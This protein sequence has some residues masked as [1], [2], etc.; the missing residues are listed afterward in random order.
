MNDF[1]LR[2]GLLTKA[3]RKSAPARGYIESDDSETHSES[4]EGIFYLFYCIKISFL[5]QEKKS[6]REDSA[7]PRFRK[8]AIKSTPGIHAQPVVVHSFSRIPDD[9]IPDARMVTPG[10]EVV[11]AMA[12]ESV[13]EG[14]PVTNEDV[15]DWL[16][17]SA[18]RYFEIQKKSPSKLTPGVIL[19]SPIFRN[20]SLDEEDFRA[21]RNIVLEHIKVLSV[22]AAR[23]R[24]TICYWM[25][26]LNFSA[27]KETKPRKKTNR[28]EPS[29]LPP[30]PGSLKPGVYN[31]TEVQATAIKEKPYINF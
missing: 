4:G 24:Q 12:P 28:F 13:I 16:L 18:T 26:N 8:Y 1:L 27:N 25:P 23:N 19:K 31:F 20:L 6:E 3:A 5:F 10:P 15:R 14:R 29:I 22:R 9:Q 7:K 21:R 11:A 17:K 30:P 2:K